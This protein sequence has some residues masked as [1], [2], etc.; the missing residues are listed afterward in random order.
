LGGDK[1]RKEIEEK[2]EKERL[3]EQ[4]KQSNKQK[5]NGGVGGTQGNQT[6][7][8]GVTMVEWPKKERKAYNDDDWNIRVPG[9]TCGIGVNDC[10]I[11]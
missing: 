11:I 1:A 4:K 9:Y 3:E 5:V 10:V 6:G 7:S 8:D 2:R